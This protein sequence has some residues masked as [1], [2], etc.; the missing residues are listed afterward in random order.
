VPCAS[1]RMGSGRTARKPLPGP[2]AQGTA[3]K[4][5]ERVCASLMAPKWLGLQFQQAFL[6]SCSVKS[7]GQ[8]VTNNSAEATAEATVQKFVT[9]NSAETTAEATVQKFEEGLLYMIIMYDTSLTGLGHAHGCPTPLCT[10]GPTTGVL[11]AEPGT[12]RN[13]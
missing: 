2:G 12:G 11:L 13:P 4:A 5:C 7:A 10:G 9:S 8:F 6:V 1:K 3:Q